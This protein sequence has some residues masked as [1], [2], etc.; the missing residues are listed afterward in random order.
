MTD[1]EKKTETQSR[2]AAVSLKLPPFW[3]NDPT[4][5]FAQVEAQ[6]TTRGIT[7]EQ[8]QYAY[9]VASLQ[10]EIAQEVRDLLLHPPAKQP[11]STLKSELIKRTSASEQRRLHQLLISE[12][13]GD[14]KPSQ[15]LR[16]MRQLLGD[17]KLDDNFLRQ[18]FLQ[19]LPTNVQLILATTSETIDVEQLAVIADK[20]MEVTPSVHQVS[21]IVPTPTVNSVNA[22]STEMA[23]LR[24]MV[25]ALT[26]KVEALGRQQGNR[27]N[28]SRSK[29]RDGKSS[30]RRTRS[31]S[32]ERSHAG[33]QCWYHWQYGAAAEKGTP[34]CNFQTSGNQNKSPNSTASD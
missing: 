34:P 27:T 10:P 9:V 31:P 19:R 2:L 25:A 30:Q 20:I 23:E 28:R 24:E 12:E 18:L 17:S 3:P 26:L 14:R 11:Y 4:I 1:P 32:S 13:L 15:L 22:P 8:T 21:A 29:P 16:R 5:W 7:S 6:F 33:S